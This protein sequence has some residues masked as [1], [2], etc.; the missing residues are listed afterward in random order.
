[1][2]PV[3]RQNLYKLVVETEKSIVT[4]Q[5]QLALLKKMVDLPEIKVRVITIRN[6]TG[7]DVDHRGQPKNKFMKHFHEALSPKEQE[8]LEADLN[9]ILEEMKADDIL[10]VYDDSNACKSY[11]CYLDNKVLSVKKMEN[12]GY[13]HF[14]P[15]EALDLLKKFNIETKDQVEKFWDC[16]VQGIIIN[17]NCYYFDPA[18]WSC[19]EEAVFRLKDH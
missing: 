7:L 3:E 11:Y 13:D 18:S 15:I 19:R 9:R 10:R 4:L 16:H 17:A 8:K 2:D 5:K 12:N 6:L 14:L 1:M